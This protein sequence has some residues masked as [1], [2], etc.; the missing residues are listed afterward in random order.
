M[1]ENLC[2]LN[3]WQ[4]TQHATDM[5][6]LLSEI[7]LGTGKNVCWTGI[8]TAN[9]PAVLDAASA[10]SGAKKDVS[11]GFILEVLSTAIVSATVKCNHAGEIAGMRRLYDTIGGLNA[12]PIN[13]GLGGGPQSLKAGV[14]SAQ[15]QTD[16]FNE[17]LLN[18]FVQLLQH[19]VATA[20]KGGSVEKSQFRESC[21]QA[22]ALLLSHMVY[23]LIFCL[24]LSFLFG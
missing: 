1:Q 7:R 2:E 3:A 11:E 6:S 5:V 13:F 18:R 8:R 21:S 14:P 24:I 22:T 23:F 20:E 16:S 9:I 15:V 17:I 19:F 4:R 12:S 10:A